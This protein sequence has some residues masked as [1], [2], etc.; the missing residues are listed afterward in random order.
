MGG[1][2]EEGERGQMAAAAAAGRVARVS[3]VS[4]RAAGPVLRPVS[5]PPSTVPYV[6][7][8]LAFRLPPTFAFFVFTRHRRFFFSRFSAADKQ[9]F[10]TRVFR[11]A[12]PSHSTI[13]E[14][15]LNY[16]VVMKTG[17][18]RSI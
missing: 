17:S 8:L 10:A 1:G 15:F 11:F 5:R 6:F 18:R 3:D 9:A 13:Y 14:H 2:W 12:C 7:A 16:D 4:S